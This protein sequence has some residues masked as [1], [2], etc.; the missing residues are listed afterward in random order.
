MSEGPFN[1]DDLLDAIEVDSDSE[2]GDVQR[3]IDEA[4]EAVEE[5][6]ARAQREGVDAEPAAG[7]DP[8]LDMLRREVAELRDRSIRTL[9][10]FDNFRKRVDRERAEERRFAGSEILRD[11]LPVVDNLER[12]L[13][14]PGGVAELKEGVE[15]ILKQIEE[16]LQRHGV[17][18]VDPEGEPFDPNLHEAVSRE[19]DPELREPTVSE[20]LQRGYLLYERLLR[21]AVVA[22]RVPVANQEAES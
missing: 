12:A 20:V 16:T 4:L 7:E 2:D 17:E 10:D 21:P 18:K 3:A 11:F 6:R 8:E 9:A 14:A 1:G 5:V 22:V 13:Q 15:L 19:D